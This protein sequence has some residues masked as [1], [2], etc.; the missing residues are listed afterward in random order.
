MPTGAA[1]RARELGRRGCFALLLHRQRRRHVG[2]EGTALAIV[3]GLALSTAT[4][5]PPPAAL[6]PAPLL[7]IHSFLLHYTHRRS[8]PIALR[9]TPHRQPPSALSV[10]PQLHLLS[11]LCV[12]AISTSSLIAD[13]S[14]A[15]RA[16]CLPA[17]AIVHALQHSD[18]PPHGLTPSLDTPPSVTT[19]QSLHSTPMVCRSDLR[20]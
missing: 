7:R 11:P 3:V 9:A 17:R 14:L 2:Q 15:E 19:T 5:A 8:L 20:H 1:R 4:I 18:Q 16:L 10:P 13:L 12:D 6:S